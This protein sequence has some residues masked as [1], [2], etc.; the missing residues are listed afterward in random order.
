MKKIK[1]IKLIEIEEGWDLEK[2]LRKIRNGLR[3]GEIE[4]RRIIIKEIEK[5]DIKKN[6]IKKIKIL[7]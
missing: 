5:M 7:M 1:I 2:L 3:S 6:M 4:K